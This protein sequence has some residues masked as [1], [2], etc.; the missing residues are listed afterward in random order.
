[1]RMWSA[2]LFIICL[3]MGAYA[4]VMIG[5]FNGTPYD[6]SMYSPSADVN[7]WISTWFNGDVTV[8]VAALMGGIGIGG[9][10]A[11]VTRQYTYA[12]IAV[13]LVVV[14]A[15]AK[16]VQAAFTA[17]P[18]I[19]NSLGAPVYFT[20]IVSL[21]YGAVFVMFILEVLAQRQLT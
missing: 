16:P 8:W 5:M 1:M 21:L 11:V 4:T 14:V 15:V 18:V 13:L 12:F 10:L 2:V 20:T 7:S 19:M 3:N 17:V 9:L 6:P